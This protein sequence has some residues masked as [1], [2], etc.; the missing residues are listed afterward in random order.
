M[1]R[2]SARG[3][4]LV[5]VV[6]ALA[7]VATVMMGLASAMRTLGQTAGKLD[8]KLDRGEQMRAVM[9]FLRASLGLLAGPE[10]PGSSL[11]KP[12]PPV[13]GNEREVEW[14]GAFP[15]RFGVGGMHRFRLR[16]EQA[17][18]APALILEFAPLE[19]GGLPGPWG[20][21]AP[22]VRV[23]GVT[24]LTLQ[25][26][27][28]KGNW[29]QTWESPLGAPIRID[30]SIADQRGPWPALVVAPQIADPL[31]GAVLFTVGSGR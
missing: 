4:T 27:D 23:D 5:E 31:A 19:H 28:S 25:Y 6:V 11:E 17:V 22:E 20:A 30:L 29:K 18:A 7:L 12:P 2:T 10:R 3:F 16:V 24:A 1:I 26:Q 21:V 15:A 8:E 13:F 9:E 14:T